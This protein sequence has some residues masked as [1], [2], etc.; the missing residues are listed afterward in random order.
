MVEQD[1]R[2][3][4]LD[5]NFCAYNQKAIYCFF[6]NSDL[7]FIELIGYWGIVYFIHYLS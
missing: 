3:H 4:L 2:P 6:K 7:T 5:P 1:L